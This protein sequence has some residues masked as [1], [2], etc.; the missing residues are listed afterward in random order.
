MA[1]L[2]KPYRPKTVFRAYLN[3]TLSIIEGKANNRN[4]RRDQAKKQYDEFMAWSLESPDEVAAWRKERE[5]EESSGGHLRVED[6][7]VAAYKPY[8]HHEVDEKYMADTEKLRA[9]IAAMPG[10]STELTDDIYELVVAYNYFFRPE[11]FW[12]KDEFGGFVTLLV[13]A[14]AIYYF[15]AIWVGWSFIGISVVST[16]Y[17]FY[18]LSTSKGG[19]VSG[20]MLLPLIFLFIVGVFMVG[21]SAGINLF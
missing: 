10:D 4:Q 15:G 17:F 12:E 6:D 11:R 5:D 8:Q 2:R 16:T 14:A 1:P 20:L 9:I 13:I 3:E 21:V 18:V 7:P 19:T